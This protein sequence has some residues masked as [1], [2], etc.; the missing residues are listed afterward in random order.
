MVVVVVMVTESKSISR[1]VLDW[2]IK[3]L[4]VMLRMVVMMTRRV[5]VLATF[6]TSHACRCPSAI[7]AIIIKDV[8]F[9]LDSF[10]LSALLRVNPPH[11]FTVLWSI[12]AIMWQWASAQRR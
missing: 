1:W 11:H 7:V 6:S 4:L 3:S 5:S 10:R 8:A 2:R 9:I 12:L